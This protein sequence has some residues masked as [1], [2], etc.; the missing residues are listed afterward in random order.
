M[1]T[2]SGEIQKER[3]NVYKRKLRISDE[4][5]LGRKLETVEEFNGSYFRDNYYDAFVLTQ[6]ILNRN[7]KVERIWK[8]QRI[9]FGDRMSQERLYN[10]ITFCGGRGTGKTS[11]MDSVVRTLQ[12]ASGEYKN[13]IREYEKGDEEGRKR[14]TEILDLSLLLDRN[15][16]ICLDGIDAS[17]LEGKEDILDVILSKMLQ[18]LRRRI[19]VRDKNFIWDMEVGGSYSQGDIFRKFEEIC[20]NKRKLLWRMDNPYESGESSTEQLS[21]LAGSL[22]IREKLQELIPIYLQALTADRSKGK[23]YLVINIDDLD[24]HGNAYQMLEQLHRYLMIP[25]VIIYIAVSEREIM[26]VCKKHFEET[27]DRPAELAMSYLEKVLP[28][29]RRIYLP[30]TF[31]G[32]FFNIATGENPELDDFLIKDYLLTEIAKRTQVFFDGK[33]SETHFYEIG[34]LRTLFN[35]YFLLKGMGRI[36]DEDLMSEKTKIFSEYLEMLNSNFDKLKNDVIGRMAT[37]KLNNDLQYS[38]FRDYYRE[39]FSSN[40]EYLVEQII[41]LIGKQDFAEEYQKFG[42]SYGEVLN[43]L[44]NLSKEKQEF[45]PL[46]QCVLAMATIELTQNY[47]YTFYT[48]EISTKV[49]WSEYVSGSVC[50]NWANQM[51]PAVKKQ[52]NKSTSIAYVKNRIIN[53]KIDVVIKEQDKDNEANISLSNLEFDSYLR[54]IEES[55]IV[56]SFELFMA[57][58]IKKGRMGMETDDIS[59]KCLEGTEEQESRIM[60]ELTDWECTF[61]IL[62]AVVNI[63]DYE[64]IEGIDYKGY[65]QKIRKMLLSISKKYFYTKEIELNADQLKKLEIKMQEKSLEKAYKEWY[66]MYGR[67]ALPLYSMDIMYNILKRVKRKMKKELPEEI[68][69]NDFLQAVRQFYKAIGD[70]LKKEDE[71]YSKGKEGERESYTNFCCGFCCFPFIRPFMGQNYDGD[72]EEG[73]LRKQQ[74]D[75]LPELFVKLFNGIVKSLVPQDR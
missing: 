56:E 3:Y 10:I 41:N 46:I 1:K 60:L 19:K 12:T 15:E 55:K 38:I 20:Q 25:Q 17:L 39:D 8:N 43:V 44:Y 13:F 2:R 75:E 28:Y 5:G 30:E 23:Q 71:F 48:S 21:D 26:A 9:D 62:G 73:G 35:F 42:Y 4:H 40:G 34:N 33:G 36:K 32:D 27:Y 52:N 49:K 66:E 37:E 7:V 63:I 61:D 59:I 74:L 67:I 24:I 45:K 18:L 29:S 22:D 64:G 6:K 72:K 31:S 65:F 68:D 16:F 50:G 57:F 53:I 70:E 58:I 54:W 51:L 69:T 11:V 14:N 47:I